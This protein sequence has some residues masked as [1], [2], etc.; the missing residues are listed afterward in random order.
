MVQLQNNIYLL[1]CFP[2]IVSV[3]TSKNVI[4]NPEQ[5]TVNSTSSQSHGSK[6]VAMKPAWCCDITLIFNKVTDT[7]LHCMSVINIQWRDSSLPTTH[8][9]NL[10]P[11]ISMVTYSK[12]SQ[13]TKEWT[14]HINSLSLSVSLS[15]IHTHT[16]SLKHTL[17]T[18]R[19][20]LCEGMC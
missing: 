7:A 16:R 18:L 13:W 5:M 12:T 3:H 2:K 8:P 19:C 20:I 4:M 9:L 10:N 1:K 15:Y 6:P 17:G 14:L 11:F